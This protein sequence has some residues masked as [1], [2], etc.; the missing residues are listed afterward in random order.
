MGQISAK[1]SLAADGT[2]VALD[3]SVGN[4]SELTSTGAWWA[5]LHVWARCGAVLAAAFSALALLIDLRPHSAPPVAALEATEA[6]A[7]AAEFE[8]D[9]AARPRYRF[10]VIPG[11]VYSG[12]ELAAVIRRDAVVAAQYSTVD[13]IDVRPVVTPAPRMAFVSYRMGDR[14]YW[15]RKPVQIPAG[16]ILLTDGDTEIRARCGNGVSDVAREPVSDV[17]PLAADLDDSSVSG[18]QEPLGAGQW[19][20]PFVPFLQSAQ[21]SAFANGTGLPDELLPLGALGPSAL[22]FLGAAGSASPAFIDDGE[23]S[24]SSERV[25]SSSRFLTDGAGSGGTDATGGDSNP[26]GSNPWVGNPGGG[27]PPGGGTV[28]TT[29]PGSEDVI[30]EEEAPSVPEPSTMALLGLGVAAAALRRRRQTN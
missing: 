19:G 14:V 9:A 12:E 26:D 30:E 17:Q 11:G 22:G 27:S 18:E 13:T 5:R 8:E 10:S 7:S 3:G 28:P 23:P 24:G 2:T 15:T 21:D 16:E 6:A 29:Y 20:T 4:R 1:S 25:N